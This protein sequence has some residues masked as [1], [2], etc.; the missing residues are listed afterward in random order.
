M[1]TPSQIIR[2]YKNGRK[3]FTLVE[4][5]IASSIFTVVSLIG[6]EI[7]VNVVRIQKRIYLE[8]AIYEDGRFMMERLSREIRQNAIDYEEYYNKNVEGAG[9]GREYGC[10]A[11]RF[12]NPGT[13]G[14]YNGGF[15]AYCNNDVTNPKDS[16]GCIID[17]KTL[18]VNTGQNPYAGTPKANK[19]A[20]DANAMCDKNTIFFG[21]L[22][23]CTVANTAQNNQSQLYLID[24]KGKQKTIFARKKIVDNS[25]PEPDEYALSIIRLQGEDANKDDVVEKWYDN[26]PPINYYCASVF[27]CTPGVPA[28]F[29]YLETSLN[30]TQP[31]EPDMLYKGFVPISPLRTNVSSLHFYISPLEDPRKAFAETATADAIQQQPHVTIVMTLKPAASEITGYNETPPSI[32]LQTTVTSRVYNEVKSYP[33]DG[34]C[35]RGY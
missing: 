11:T 24:A 6:V 12:Y 15:G 31:P 23:D 5:I 17:K 13:G 16:P 32:T 10:Y 35:S 34:V 28:V 8:N 26:G 4:V 27:D 25:D 22:P 29:S 19:N 2:D 1:R 14:P 20:S 30:E 7:F 9:L 21:P 3:G 33:G 18:D